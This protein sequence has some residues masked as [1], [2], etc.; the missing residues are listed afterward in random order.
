MNQESKQLQVIEFIWVWI[1]DCT[2][3]IGSE[4]FG[5]NDP[6]VLSEE[7]DPGSE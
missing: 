7:F 1:D 3:K 2:Q 6:V 5:A 4:P